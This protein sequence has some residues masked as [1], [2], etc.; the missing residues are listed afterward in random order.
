MGDFY[1]DIGLADE[2]RRAYLKSL[3]IAARLVSAEPDRVDYQRDLSVSYE[4]MGDIDRALGEG[5][6]AQT[7]YLKSLSIRDRLATAE[8]SRADYQRDLIVS[9]AKMSENVPN[10]AHKYLSRALEIAL[11]LQNQGRLAQADVWMLEEL[12]GRLDGLSRN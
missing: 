8:P 4:R 9:C 1:H 3:A 7:A 6:C 11:R 2:A 10:E 5:D 12:R